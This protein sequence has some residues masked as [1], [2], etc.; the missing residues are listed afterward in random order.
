MNKKEEALQGD[1][2]FVGKAKTTPFELPFDLKNLE[3]FFDYIAKMDERLTKLE[4]HY[5]DT[6]PRRS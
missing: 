5:D 1:V 2:H 6:N 4:A 3:W